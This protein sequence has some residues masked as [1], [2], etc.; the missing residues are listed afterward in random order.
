MKNK[1]HMIIPIDAG[2]AFD[3]IQYPFIIK[4][5]LNKVSMEGAYLNIMK[6]I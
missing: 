2:E 1:T 4:K 3:K 6:A 5:K